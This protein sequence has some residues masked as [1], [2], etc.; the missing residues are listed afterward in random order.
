LTFLPNA[1]TPT[2]VMAGEADS[3]TPIS[4]AEQAYAC[5]QLHGVPSAFVRFPATTHSSGTMRPSHIAA[6]IACTLAW[7]A[8]YP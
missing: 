2:I 8:R 3:R 6:E 1:T 4:E 7:I 5:L